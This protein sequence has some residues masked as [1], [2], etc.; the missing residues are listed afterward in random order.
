VTGTSSQN[1]GDLP[2]SVRLLQDT[3]GED[4]GRAMAELV[5]DLAPGAPLLFNTAFTG[6]ADFASGIDALRACGAKVIVDDITYF[7]EPMFQDGIIAQA[8]QAA[9]DAGVVYLSSA[10]NNG[11][12]G[13]D[14]VFVDSA[15]F[16]DNDNLH[17]FENGG[18]GAAF[19]VPAGCTPRLI[20]QWADPFDGTLGQGASSDFDLVVQQCDGNDCTQL[21]GGDGVQG[22]S[23]QDGGPGGDPIELINLPKAAKS[24]SYVVGVAR[25]CGDT[26]RFRLVLASN[27]CLV[28]ANV[29]ATV[30][31]EATIFGH[32]AAAGVLAVAAVDYREIA[33]DGDLTPPSGVINVEYFSSLGGNLPF[34]YG[35]TGTPLPGAPQT[36]SKPEIAAPDN[37]DTTFFVP[38]RDPDGNGLPNFSGTSAA[39]PHAAAVAAL[40]LEKNPALSPAGVRDALTSTALDIESPGF[41]FLSGFGLIDAVDAV[42]AA[43][44]SPSN[45]GLLENPQSNGFQSGISVVSGW[46]CQASHVTFQI[47]DGAALD[48]AYGT[49][50]ADTIG[51]CGDA[52]NGFGALLNWNLLGDGTHTLRVFADGVQFGEASFAVATF[53]GSFLAGASGQYLLN[54]FPI[55][56]DS[57]VVRWQEASQNFVIVDA[58]LAS[59][60][61]PSAPAPPSSVAGVLENPAD[62]S[63]QSGIGVISGWVCSANQVTVQIDG[64]AAVPASY[65][66]ARNDTFA[67]CG[68]A[69]NGFGLLFNWSLLGDG[70]HTVTALADGVPFAQSAFTVTTLGTSFLAGASGQ[71]L[72]PDFVDGLSVLVR[73]QEAQQNFVIVGTE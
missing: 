27:G 25:F 59:S 49:P 1:S 10:A 4:E 47:D 65:G 28:P 62:A 6:E 11:T 40:M 2:A 69:N 23:R 16:D 8:A 38:N 29:D 72:L 68:D 35:P 56:G 22:C 50:R 45:P 63:F 14:N 53:G 48:A 5:H 34:F 18:T 15:P 12:F 20:L 33:Q 24:L 19:V 71:Y 30:L 60:A 17:L 46:V 26:E 39:A 54:D 31:K 43:A 52:N 3:N 58:Q 66:T 9:V 42:Q 64:G 44:G 13:V 67:I 32:P 7:Q 36:R 57:V 61:Q 55:D 73:W 51:I 21:S 41:D 70:T 37:V